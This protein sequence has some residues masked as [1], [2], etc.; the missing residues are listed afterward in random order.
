MRKRPGFEIGGEEVL[1]G[2]RRTIDL[3]VSS[4]SDHTP[5]NMSAHIVHGKG[6]GPVLFVSAGVHGD[7][8]IGIEIVRRLLKSPAL[9]GLRGT[10]IVVPIVNSFGFINRSRYLPDRR[11]LNRSFP[12][13][14]G[15]SLAARLAHLFLNE[16]VSR[17]DIGVDL[18]SAAIHR[19]NYPQVR[20]SPDD[21]PARA[22]AEEFGAPIIMESPIRQGSL[23]R[24]AKDM[25]KTVL[26][27][28][29]GEGLRFD[30]VS[31]RSGQVGILRVM[32]S[33]QMI[34]GRGV[35][36]AKAP[37]QICSSSKWLRAPMGGLFRSLK[38]DGDAV[39]RKDVLGVV[40]DPF[41]EDETDVVAPFDGIIVGRAVLPVVNEGDA[42]FH[43]A[44][45]QSVEKAEDAM[46]DHSSQLSDDPMFDEDEII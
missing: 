24:S 37:P 21:S 34:S 46:D 5:V 1:P 45:V 14:E 39:R 4:L 10:L 27:F 3:P 23:R 38:A 40:S 44:R 35:A 41:G 28:E 16:I 30:E 17:S 25:G 26:L 2:Q 33:L 13:N 43:L 11:D 42:V 20:V 7:E 12:G 9:R 15:G 8:V 19:I 29:A 22:L 6:D 18:H 31:V 32:K 36:A